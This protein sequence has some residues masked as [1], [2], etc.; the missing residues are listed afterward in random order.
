MKDAMPD[1]SGLFVIKNEVRRYMARMLSTPII[2]PPSISEVRSKMLAR[3]PYADYLRTPE[4]E[5]IREFMRE[6]FPNCAY[7]GESGPVHVHHNNYPK[8]GNERPMDLTVLCQE[9]H[10]RMHQEAAFD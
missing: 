4:W 2:S 9:C 7:C 3:L 10:A 1:Q 5:E 8:R 6:V